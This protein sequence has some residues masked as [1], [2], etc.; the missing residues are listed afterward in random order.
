MEYQGMEFEELEDGYKLKRGKD[1]KTVSV[2]E[3]IEGKPVVSI[4]AKAF[5]DFKN[6]ERIHFPGFPSLNVESF[7]SS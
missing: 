1:E 3:S 7:S 4:G 5:K 2:P 6:L